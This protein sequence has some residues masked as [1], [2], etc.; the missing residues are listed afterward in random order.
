[1]LKVIAALLVLASGSLAQ[2][3]SDG[4]FQV[5]YS[6]HQP[7]LSAVQM[8]EAES[9]YKRTCEVVQREFRSASSTPHP[10][11]KVVIGSDIDEVYGVMGPNKNV[12]GTVEIRLKKWDPLLF[13]RGV[14]VIAFDQMLT[15]AIIAEL[16]N[17][18]IRYSAATV[19]LAGLK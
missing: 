16:G 8:R 19:D 17:R 18:A 15:T 14:V 5:Q 6:K 11:F 10:R 3:A 1:M 12:N 2:S 4:S 13:T 9:L 7:T